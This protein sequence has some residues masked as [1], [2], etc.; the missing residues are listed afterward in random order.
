MSMIR[1]NKVEEIIRDLPTEYRYTIWI[2]IRIARVD[3]N[4]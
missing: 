2:R 1:K 4:Y 3:K